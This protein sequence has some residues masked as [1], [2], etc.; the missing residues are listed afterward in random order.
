MQPDRDLDRELRDLGPRVEYPPVPDLARSVR[1]RLE[2]ETGGTGPPPRARPQLWWIAAAALVLLVA[3]PVVSLA[4]RGTVGGAFSAGEGAAGGVAESG[5]R[6][7]GGGPN[8]LTE[9]AAA[10][11][12][13]SAD[14]EGALA[15]GAGQEAEEKGETQESLQIEQGA[16]ET[17]RPNGPVPDVVGMELTAACEKLSAREYVGYVVRAV[18]DPNARPGLVVEQRPLPGRKGHV[19]GPVDL[20]VSE[21]YPEDELR[22]LSGGRNPACLDATG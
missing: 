5:G 19:G 18:D 22:R 14:D 6:E 12:T 10:G 9:D 20:T 16:G 17:G 13:H 15:A 7:T 11:P 2:T 21:P 4:V 1:D 3:V 8:R